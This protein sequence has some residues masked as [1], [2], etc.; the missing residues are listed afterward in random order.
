M[1]LVAVVVGLFLGMIL[2]GVL[3]DLLDRV[4]AW[5]V[6]SGG[7]ADRFGKKVIEP[8][9]RELGLAEGKHP[10]MGFFFLLSSGVVYVMAILSIGIK[11]FSAPAFAMAVEIWVFILVLLAYRRR[12]T[13]GR[14]I[15]RLLR[16]SSAT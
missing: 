5:L 14:S 4:F 12:T 13:I 7:P 2:K 1:C 6:M 10:L 3:L 11:L 15:Q 9:L 16:R 8:F